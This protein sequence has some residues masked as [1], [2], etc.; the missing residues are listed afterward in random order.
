MVYRL[1]DVKE[2]WRRLGAF[3]DLVDYIHRWYDAVY[4]HNYNFVGFRRRGDHETSHSG[5]C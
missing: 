2:E 4:D 3:G 5:I 1:N